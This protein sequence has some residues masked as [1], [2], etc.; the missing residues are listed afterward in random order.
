MLRL[1]GLLLAGSMLV[2]WASMASATCLDVR[3]RESLSFAGTLTYQ[4][5]PGP[6]NYEDVKKGDKPERAYI[7]KLDGPICA[8]GDEFLDGKEMFDRVQLLAD[9]SSSAG[10]ATSQSLQ[11]Y[12]G[13]RVVVSG[14]SGFGAQTGHHHAPL[15]M[16][17]VSIEADTAPP[18]P[19]KP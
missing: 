18:G 10:R 11:G 7:I 12:D 19:P 3:E 1:A 5:F 17:L 14:K 15:L 8:T 16:T 4:T 9:D 6:P 2:G 13:K